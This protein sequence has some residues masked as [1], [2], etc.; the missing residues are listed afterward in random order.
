MI[1]TQ[2]DIVCVFDSCFGGLW[3]LELRF[4]SPQHNTLLMTAVAM[5]DMDCALCRDVGK[6]GQDKFLPWWVV[7]FSFMS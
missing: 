3:R 6:G 4:P 1:N 5:L 7:S 2:I